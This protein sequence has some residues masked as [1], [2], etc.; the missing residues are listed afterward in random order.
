[1]CNFAV[2]ESLKSIS[3]T[4]SSFQLLKRRISA[5][6]AFLIQILKIF[7]DCVGLLNSTQSVCQSMLSEVFVMRN[8]DFNFSQYLRQLSLPSKSAF[9]C[10]LLHRSIHGRTEMGLLGHRYWSTWIQKY[11]QNNKMV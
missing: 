6:S 11:W 8:H 4:A 7:N 1:M 10:P 9:L 5:N 2:Q 3:R